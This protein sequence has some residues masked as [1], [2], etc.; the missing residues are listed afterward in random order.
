[1][2]GVHESFARCLT[3]CG[4]A[5][6]A[7][8]APPHRFQ[9]CLGPLR[10]KG[11]KGNRTQ[12]FGRQNKY[13]N[14][15]LEGTSARISLASSSF[16]YSQAYF[17]TRTGQAS[18]LRALLA[19][20]LLSLGCSQLFVLQPYETRRQRQPLTHKLCSAAS[21]LFTRGRVL[22]GRRRLSPHVTHK[23]S[24]SLGCPPA[25]ALGSNNIHQH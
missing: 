24:H 2:L 14:S 21:Y 16:R 11:G 3:G 7:H 18:M 6:A 15:L 4:A 13:I 25:P 19:P 10:N 5:L 17:A 1:M 20:A 23:A 8:W 9:T 12:E 22:G